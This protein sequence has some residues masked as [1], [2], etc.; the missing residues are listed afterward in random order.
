LASF[1]L[2]VPNRMDRGLVAVSDVGVSL[3]EPHRGGRHRSVFTYVHD[4]WQLRPNITVDLGLRHE[5]YTPVVGFHGRGGMS[6][7]SPETNTLLVAGYGDNPENLGVQS[8]WLNFNPRTGISW[9]INDTNVVRAGYGVSAEGGP[10]QAGQL[11]PITQSQTITAPNSFAAAGSL[12]AGIPAPSFAQIPEN[13]I[14]PATGP[15]LSQTLS[16]LLLEPHHNGQLRSW[17]VAYQRVLPG[18]F[19]AE[20]AYVGNRANDEWA[21]ENINASHT[22]GADQAGQPLFVKFGRTAT[23]TV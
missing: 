6:T 20:V 3:D 14:L 5:Y 10:S 15:L 22:L 4:K 11:Y 19:T 9:R 13:G 2:D 18:G 21:G 1:L 16:A 8:Y 17:N 12:A 23:T 7:Y